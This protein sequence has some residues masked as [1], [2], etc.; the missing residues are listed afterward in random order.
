MKKY[1]RIQIIIIFCTFNILFSQ[2]I[3]I[4]PD[5]GF[6]PF[7]EFFITSLNLT[8]GENHSYL[9]GYRIFEENDDYSSNLE[10]SVKYE[11]ILDSQILGDDNP[12]TIIDVSTQ[13]FILQA[14]VRISNL[15]MTS[16]SNVLYDMELNQ[17]E[18]SGNIVN[19][20]DFS[21]NEFLRSTILSTGKLI[22]GNYNFTFSVL[23]NGN[24]ADKVVEKFVSSSPMYI[25]LITPGGELSDTTFNWLHDQFPVFY[26]ETGFCFGCENFIRVSEFNSSI[27]HSQDDAI[28]D[29]TVLPISQDDQW[30]KVDQVPFQYPTV[31]AIPLKNGKV[32]VWQ[33]KAEYGSNMGTESILSPVYAFK[34]NDNSSLVK[35]AA[36]SIHPL[37][38]QIRDVIGNDQFEVYFGIDASLDGYSPLGEYEINNE[39]VSME[40][41]EEILSKLVKENPS[42]R[43]EVK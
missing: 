4:S 9:F 38:Q 22:D 43:F 5:P 37:L 11:L 23:I 25:D 13:P 12:V 7:L 34:Y 27:H 31:G 26:W 24:V 8:T 36:E 16:L 3:K 6:N 40:S 32:Y 29:I 42:F 35:S 39:S 28:E 21:T 19:A 30:Y 15:D 33:V 18:M 14:P 1:S 10:I 2:S 41:I 17:I 20:L